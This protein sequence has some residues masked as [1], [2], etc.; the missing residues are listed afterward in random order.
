MESDIAD[1]S[2]IATFR[3]WAIPRD[4]IPNPF[5]KKPLFA[6][7]AGSLEQSYHQ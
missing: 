5:Q 1:L 4:F 7:T 2:V 6:G 3:H